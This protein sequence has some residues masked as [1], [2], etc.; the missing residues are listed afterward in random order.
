MLLSIL[1]LLLHLNSLQNATTTTPIH[2]SYYSQSSPNPHYCYLNPTPI[3]ALLF[4]RRCHPPARTSHIFLSLLLLSGDVHLNP[5][6]LQPSQFTLCTYNARS[7]LADTHILSID[8][9]AGQY[10]PNLFAITETHA[11]TTTT[12]AEIIDATP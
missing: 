2:P 7:M 9:L 6:P 5:G 3:G 11:L 10:H 12:P 8:D 4:Q 1:S